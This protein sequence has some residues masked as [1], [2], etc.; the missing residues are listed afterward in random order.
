MVIDYNKMIEMVLEEK[1]D[2]NFEKIRDME[3]DE[4][5]KAKTSYM[6]TDY[7]RN[8]QLIEAAAAGQQGGV[9]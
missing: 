7:H 2:L 6:F 9:S 4:L 1:P 8:K 5:V 3:W